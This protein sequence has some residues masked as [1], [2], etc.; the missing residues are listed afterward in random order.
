MP[1]H[2]SHI[3]H[4]KCINDWLQRDN[5]CPLCKQCISSDGDDMDEK[6]LDDNYGRQ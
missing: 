4:S 1:C 2:D 5:S 3:F 6:F